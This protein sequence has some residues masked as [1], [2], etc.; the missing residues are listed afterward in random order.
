MA[1][2]VGVLIALAVSAFVYV[3][4]ETLPIGLMLLISADLHVSPSAVGLLVTCYG[5]VVVAASVPLTHLTRNVPRRLLLPG[6]LAVFVLATVVSVATSDYWVLLAS[7]MVIALSQALFWSV[8]V[9]TAAGLFPLRVR[10]RVLAVVFAGSSLA[11]VVGLPVGTWLGEQMGWR[12]AFL[13]LSGV[14][15][16]T[17][18]TI[19][20]L[21]P[22]GRPGQ[23]NAATGTTPDARRYWLLMATTVLGITGAFTAFTYVTPFLTEVAV[24]S[25]AAIGPLLLLRG[26]AGVVGVGVGGWHVDRSPWGATFVPLLL[27]TEAL[28]GLYV[29]G[30]S[31]VVSAVLVAVAGLAFSA[32]ASAVG[33]RT[34][35]VAPGNADLAAAGSSTAFN[36]G[37]TVGA[38]LGSVLLSGL[39]VRV[40]ALAGGLLSLVAVAVALTE[41]RRAPDG[42]PDVDSARRAVAGSASIDSGGD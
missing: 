31:R 1:R 33:A 29:F 42:R 24:F 22:T 5:L 8:V 34:L 9:S 3:T 23:T 10:G 25:A 15:V 32:Y 38:L 26:I 30:E 17:L 11:S 4:T 14:G 19:A 13:V 28:F 37:I 40:T 2:A 20:A 12:A 7:R 18:V 35:Q 21:L 27:Q 6:V 39:G 36:I 16:L 41:P